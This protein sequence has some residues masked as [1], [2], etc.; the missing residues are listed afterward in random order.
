MLD[1]QIPEHGV[2][3]LEVEMVGIKW[4][5]EPLE[6]LLMFWVFWI[7]N[8]LQEIIVAK[9]ASAV[10]WGA[11]IFSIQAARIRLL[12]IRRQNFFHH[13]LVFPSIAKIVFIN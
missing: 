10:F 3:L 11:V 5:S 1:F 8:S 6:K 2:G 13:N 7:A 9:D 12:R 4:T